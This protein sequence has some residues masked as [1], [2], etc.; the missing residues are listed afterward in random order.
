MVL[1]NIQAFTSAD[2]LEEEVGPTMPSDVLEF[3]F[4]VL[5]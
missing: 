2:A 3:Y 5:M 1:D 4:Y